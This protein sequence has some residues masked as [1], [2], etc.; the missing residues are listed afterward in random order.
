[1]NSLGRKIL[2]FAVVMAV[3]AGA[4]WFGRKA[5]KRLTERR[6]IAQ[7]NQYL[8]K[9][10]FKNAVLCV[11]RA[12]QLNPVSGKAGRVMADTLEAVGMPAALSWRVHSAKYDPGNPTNRLLWAQTA[13]KLR[14]FK[15]ASEAL[16][17]LDETSKKTA[18]FHKLAGALAWERGNGAEAELQYAEALRLE[19]TNLTVVM[20]LGTIHLASTNL[21]IAATGRLA[22]ER[23]AT[24][25]AWRLM[26][27]RCLAADALTHKSVADALH[28][29]DQIV[30]DPGAS[31]SD[32][33]NRL[34]LLQVAKVDGFTALLSSLKESATNSPGQVYALARW[35]LKS[36]SPTAALR[37]LHS[38]PSPLLTNAPVPL[39]ITDC[40]IALQDWK[41]LL[42]SVESQE[43]GDAN[44]YR[45]ALQAKAQRELKND[46]G[47][48]TAWR[49]ALRESNQ[50]IDHLS[51][52][53]QLAAAWGWK[54]E[55]TQVL[56]ELTAQFPKDK[57]ALA[58]LMDELYTDG[59]TAGLKELL[60]R[61]SASDPSDARL[62]NALANVSLLQK[63]ELD[64]ACRLAREAYDSL[65]NDPFVISTYSYSLL[66]QN[67]VNDAVK[68]AGGLKPEAL[69]DPAIAGIFGLI[70]AQ[71]GHKDIAKEPLDRAELGEL[72]PEEK[73]M[74]RIAKAGL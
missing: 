44:F 27:L 39:I 30:A 19:P 42:G 9:K 57:P 66:L 13:I 31:F 62:K 15:S 5:Y 43:W 4:G 8:E 3:V 56:H 25:S 59:N 12:I 18:A 53:A 63:S 35:M 48:E 41:G 60:A 36:Q 14:E 28:Y 46:L 33:V 37:W 34:Q 69:Q 26:A 72:L 70:Q 71:A 55:R 10:D 40:Q 11:Q 58:Q 74:V 16:D 1:M 24:N 65:P 64:K 7:A 32:K 21:A 51:R 50:H 45:L 67:K 68:I 23:L 6:L 61:T 54:A 22:L 38:L 73:E 49:K 17:G 52:L 2:V 20:N 47:F 29:S